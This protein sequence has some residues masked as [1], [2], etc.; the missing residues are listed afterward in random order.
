MHFEIVGPIDSAKTIAR[1]S[2]I[3]E[4]KRLKRS[5]GFGKWRKRKGIALIKLENGE[6][7]TAELHWYEASGMGKHEFKIKKL[8]DRL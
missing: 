7:L 8:M 5:Y 2:G 4:L 6:I 1:G 3:R